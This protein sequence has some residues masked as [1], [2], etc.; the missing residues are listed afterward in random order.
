MEHIRFNEGTC[1]TPL[2]HDAS[3]TSRSIY[4]NGVDIHATTFPPNSGMKEEVHETKAHV[5]YVLQGQ[6]EV[7][8]HGKIVDVLDVDDAIVIHA[9]EVHEIRNKREMSAIFLAITF[10]E[11]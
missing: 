11:V 8:Q 6:I 2:G 3:V 7:L 5:F 4:K 9:G 10:D 1:Y